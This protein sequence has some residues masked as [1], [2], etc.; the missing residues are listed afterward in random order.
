MLSG[1]EAFNSSFESKHWAR[2]WGAAQQSPGLHPRHRVLERLLGSPG[3][4][5][6]S[7]I[8]T[9]RTQTN[10]EQGDINTPLIGLR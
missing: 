5:L 6:A 7:M 9:Q 1:Q 10:E 3:W 2:A 8:D 4:F